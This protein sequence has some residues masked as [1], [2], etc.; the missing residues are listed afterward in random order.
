[1]NIH[2][3]AISPRVKARAS[4]AQIDEEESH[5]VENPSLRELEKLPKETLLELIKVYSRNWLTVDGLWFS[6][7]EEIYGLDAAMALD[8]RMWRIGSLIEIK[9]I[10][11]VLNLKGGLSDILRGVD[12]MSWAPS[13]GYEYEIAQGRALWTC[14]Q[15]P[16]QEHRIKAGKGEFPCRAT[17]D[18]CF[19]NVIEVIDP[20][21]QVKCIFCP[22]GPHPKDAWCQW[23]FVSPNE[24]RSNGGGR[25]DRA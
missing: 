13:F 1:M 6:G 17:F 25:Q 24:S 10:K 5:S 11:K 2:I 23:E 21:V 12:F 22:P 14:T 20:A 15:C 4:P 7:V 3:E 16:P 18:A 9:R 19:S 8:V